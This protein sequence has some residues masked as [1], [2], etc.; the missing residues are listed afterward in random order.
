MHE[1]GIIGELMSKVESAARANS[2]TKVVSIDLSI[3][4]LAGIEPD[5]L[6]EHFVIAAAGTIAE[7]AELRIQT[8][9]EPTGILLQSLDIET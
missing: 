2:A 1:S 4:L 7:G 9:D 6:R 3:G 5:H 8:T